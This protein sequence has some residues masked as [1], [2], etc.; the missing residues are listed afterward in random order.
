MA[1]RPV[2]EEAVYYRVKKVKGHKCALVCE[3]DTVS[4]HIKS[5][6]CIPLRRFLRK[7]MI[8][9]SRDPRAKFYA[10]SL[11]RLKME[12]SRH[13][14]H[15]YSVIHPFSDFHFFWQSIMTIV[16]LLI[17]LIL[18]IYCLGDIVD[19]GEKIRG[20][21]I[22][23]LFFTIACFINIIMCFFIGYYDKNTDKVVL[24]HSRIIKNHENNEQTNNHFIDF[25]K[26]EP[27]QSEEYIKEEEI[28]IGEN[29]AGIP[30]IKTELL[31]EE[32][33]TILREHTEHSTFED[34][35]DNKVF[36]EHSC[37]NQASQSSHE[38][39][40]CDPTLESSHK[41]HINSSHLDIKKHICNL[42]D[43]Q[44]FY[45]HHLTD[46]MNRVHNGIKYK[47]TQCDYQAKRK[48]YIKEH[49]ESVHLGIKHKCSHCD[50]QATKKSNLTHHTNSVHF[51]IRNLKCI[52]CDYQ[53]A[54][55]SNLF[56]HVNS[57]H[58]GITYKCSQ[59]DYHATQKGSL[60][61]HI[62]SIH[63]GIKHYKCSHCDYQA[64][65]KSDLT[66]H[67]DRVHLKIKSIQCLQCDYQTSTNS[68]LSKHV[69][70]VHLGI[71]YKCSQ[72]DYYATQKGSLKQHT[73]SIHLGIKH[74]CSHCDYQST[75]K[76]KLTH[77][78]NSVHIKIKN[79]NY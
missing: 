9:S 6:I 7:S 36:E 55:K 48:D 31:E 52:Q 8:I 15:Y 10:K 69:K 65:R 62:E 76:S 54:T 26:I 22:L 2:L 24:Q 41:V 49:I 25:P 45:K 58:L 67:T 39:S 21:D 64:T 18:P 77:H 75:K 40:Q 20:M 60:K 27:Y 29:E 50:Y 42:C 11:D 4:K 53:T 66:H 35:L 23:F 28:D 33:E 37:E 51:K 70:S 78:I 30:K 46:H 38:Y 13:L 34:L 44:T 71:T 61:R 14:E 68:N 56:Q 57:A 79:E 43:Y 5:G 32:N 47:C 12:E 19:H 63:L 74:K 3:A 73:E 1:T 16:H 72:C 17:L 59:C